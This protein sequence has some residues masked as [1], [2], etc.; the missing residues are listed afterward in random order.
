[1]E[2]KAVVLC[3]HLNDIIAKD[4]ESIPRQHIKFVVPEIV[5]DG[6]HR[7]WWTVLSGMPVICTAA[8]DRDWGLGP[9][10]V[11]IWSSY[12]SDNLLSMRCPVRSSYHLN[13]RRVAESIGQSRVMGLEGVA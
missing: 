9:G 3:M 13:L 1:M 7:Q 12:Q 11:F 5:W 2:C 4:I 6:C 8:F 10:G